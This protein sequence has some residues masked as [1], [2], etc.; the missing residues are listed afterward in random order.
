MLQLLLH[1]PRRLRQRLEHRLQ[2]R[3]RWIRNRLRLSV[4][5]KRMEG[6][7]GWGG[8]GD[9]NAIGRAET[10]TVRGE[11]RRGPPLLSPLGGWGV[12]LCVYV[13]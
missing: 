8:G 13:L 12:C 5:E 1:M 6:G 2:Q 10:E 7:M 3:R 11:A 4:I 9:V